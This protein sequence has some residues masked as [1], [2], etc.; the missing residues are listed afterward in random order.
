MESVFCTI[1]SRLRA[2]QAIALFLS[3]KKECEESSVY[4]LCA[5]DS[6]FALFQR[7]NFSNV[8]LLKA[9]AL[10]EKT[11]EKIRQ[12]RKLNEYCWT[13][14]P[15][16][17]EWIFQKKESIKRVT[18]LDSD[19]FFWNEPTEIFA[20]QPESDVL[21][22]R[23]DI[24]VSSLSPGLADYL[25]N[26]MGDYNSG[27]ISF[28]KTAPA[29]ECL[30]W[31][32]ERCLLSCFSRPEQGDFGDQTYLNEMPKRFSGVAAIATPG[33]NL[34]HWNY[35]GKR[36]S[37]YQGRLYADDHPLIC[38]HF[39]GFRFL[40]DGSVLK[41][42]EEQRPDIPFFYSIYSDI[43]REIIL[44]VQ[45]VKPDFDGCSTQEDI[46]TI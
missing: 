23:G 5:D 28:Q 31:W 1:V 17:I 32:K 46:E 13:L 40:P 8:I 4:A 27:F 39:S 21:L 7:M 36:Y 43:L 11:L 33:V 24:S 38:Y 12:E 9:D 16:L 35:G 20:S 30:R 26:L 2:Y 18:Y 44:L 34:G 6:T 19:L 10:G 37:F 29:L 3:L 25:Q 14:K 22:S 41:I 45:R 15:L 42:H